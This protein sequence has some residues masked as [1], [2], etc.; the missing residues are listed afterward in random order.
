MNTV[1]VWDKL[2][3][4]PYKAGFRKLLKRTFKLPSGKVADFDL[5]DGGNPVCILALTSENRVILAKQFRPAQERILLELPGGG[6]EKGESFEEAAKRELLEETGYS[7][8]FEFVGTSLQSAY[9]TL[10]RYNYVATNCVQVQEPVNDQTEPIEVATMS[11]EEFRIH[12]KSG[13]LTDVATGYL[14]LDHLRLL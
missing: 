1:D 14:G 7:G 6:S 8:D 11:L 9:D 3:E 5:Y 12:I 13:E 2:S 10:V 4:E